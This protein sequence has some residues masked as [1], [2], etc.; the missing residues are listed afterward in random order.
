M[1]AR[2]VCSLFPS[3]QSWPTDAENRYDVRHLLFQL[4]GGIS[5]SGYLIFP[6]F[7]EAINTSPSSSVRVLKEHFRVIREIS[8]SEESGM[9]LSIVNNKSYESHILTDPQIIYEYLV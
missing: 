8:E 6:T 3:L 9:V 2:G 5:W 1:S 4:D 7:V